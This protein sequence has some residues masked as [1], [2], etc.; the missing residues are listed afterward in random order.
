MHLFNRTRLA[1]SIAFIV[2]VGASAVDSQEISVTNHESGSTIRYSVLLLQGTVPTGSAELKIE[3]LNA[4][5]YAGQVR[6]AVDTGR[7]KA[8]IE[9]SPGKNSL[10]LSTGSESEPTRF[11]INY[12]PQSNPHY[13]RLV[14]MTDNSGETRFAAPSNETKQDYEARLRTAALLMQ[15][16]TA[17]RMNQLGY[18]HRTFRLER[19]AEGRV[20]VNTWKGPLD[21]EDYYAMGDS[22]RWWNNVRT[23]INRDHGDPLAKNVVLAAY[24]RKDP[25]SGEMKGHTALGGANLGLFG[26]ASVFSWPSDISSAVDVFRDD[27]KFDVSG[28][29]DDSVGRSTIWGLAST[30]IGAT[31]HETGHAFGLP[32]CED[33]RGIMTRGFDQFNRAFTFRDPP[34]GRSR[35]DVPFG[36]EQ[37]A[38][39]APVSAS[40]L[41]WSRWFQ[42]DDVKLLDGRPK[43]TVDQEAGTLT[44]ECNSGVAWVGFHVK[45]N[46]RSFRE[47]AAENPPKSVTLSLEEIGAEL[48]EPPSRI[49]AMSAGGQEN[50]VDLQQRTRK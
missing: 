30:T 5:K 10:R 34:S 2:S 47:Y 16:F 3:N 43:L 41:R 22:G 39:F 33:G 49:R 48:K 15:T 31:L 28:V 23:W 20:I 35:A 13:V 25:R 44:I 18:G 32:H 29:H 40:Y 45:G 17:E 21:K 38:Y 50:A 1:V 14:W 8:L 9:L 19:D 12:Q 4:P 7:F 42:L 27:S 24:T 6:A 26:S 46:I 37:E 11:E 36:R